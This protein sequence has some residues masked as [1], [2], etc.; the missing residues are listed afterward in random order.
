MTL[1]ELKAGL[2]ALLQSKYPT[3][4]YKYYSMAV[5]E[6]Y[7]RP[8]FF[9]QFLPVKMEPV[10][11]NARKNRVIFYITIMQEKTNEAEILEM[12]QSIRDLFGLYV[13]IEDRAV[14][15]ENFDWSYTGT[16][17]NIPEISIELQWNDRI[18]HK[19]DAP[20]MERIETKKEWRN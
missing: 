12:I 17:R 10:N 13:K 15:V 6:N 1:I 2:I 5:V 9:T 14:K 20:L 3:K 7:S 18:G 11:F 4:K 8:C 19:N 16:Y